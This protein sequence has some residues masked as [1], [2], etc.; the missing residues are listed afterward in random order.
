MLFKDD[1]LDDLLK[2]AAR[3]YPLK[4]DNS[5]WEQVASELNKPFFKQTGAKNKVIIYAAAL[6]ILAIATGSIIVYTLHTEPVIAA[7]AIK[8]KTADKPALNDNTITGLRQQPTATT[9]II[10]NNQTGGSNYHALKNS[11]ELTYSSRLLLPVPPALAVSNNYQ[12]EFMLNTMVNKPSPSYTA[13]LVSPKPGY[14]SIH[15]NDLNKENGVDK[16]IEPGYGQDDDTYNEAPE[17]NT[18]GSAARL[19]KRFNQANSFYK[20][21]GTFYIGPE[22]STVKFQQVNKPGYKIGVSIGYRLSNRFN[23]E[24][25]LQREHL[26]FYSAGKY[27]DT[28]MLRIKSN[29]AVENVNASNKLTSVP[30]ALRYN[31]LSKSKGHFF[32][33]AGVNALIITHSEQYQYTVSKD[34]VPADFSKYYSSLTPPKY[35]SGVNA[36]AG[37]ELQ[38]PKFCSMKIES[39]YQSPVNNLGVGQLPVTSFGINVGIVKKLK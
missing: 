15:E 6:L 9:T 3:D 1:N 4:T 18:A 10:A 5:D 11:T 27:L 13:M 34:G 19:P 16:Y 39:Y 14:S 26:N 12:K 23:I 36:S 33:T 30:V 25:G 24:V 37:Y 22:F 2:K 20:I 7:A 35:F 28:S 21:Y 8:E 31:F 38:L 17:S 32:V 29:T